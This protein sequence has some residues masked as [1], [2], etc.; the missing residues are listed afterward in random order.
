MNKI[1]P[2]YS[3]KHSCVSACSLLFERELARYTKCKNNR[4][5]GKFMRL[6]KK[7]LSVVAFTVFL[8]VSAFAVV[9]DLTFSNVLPDGPTWGTVTLADAGNTINFVVDFNDSMFIL[10]FVNK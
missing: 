6:W 4:G 1:Q 5:R 2:F 8:P 10:G 3:L 7:A 9:Y